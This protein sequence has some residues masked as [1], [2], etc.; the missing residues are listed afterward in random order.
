MRLLMIVILVTA[1]AQ[2]GLGQS[3]DI[4]GIE[5]RLGQNVPDVLK[6]LSG[7]LVRYDDDA[8]VWMV[9]QKRGEQF[10]YLGDFQATDNK[11]WSISKSY[12]L[13]NDGESRRVYTRA[14]KD[15]RALG[16]SDC[17]MRDIEYSDDLVQ[18]VETRCGLY[19][20]TYLFPSMLGD[21]P[22]SAGIAITLAARP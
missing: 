6:A 10:S 3:L 11:V 4:G 13:R 2:G 18:G 16:G 12:T 5:V 9:T 14:A 22:V 15:L 7:Y 19:R 20:L 17:V 8:K 1:C 21:A